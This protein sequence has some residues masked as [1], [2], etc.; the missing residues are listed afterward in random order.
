VQRRYAW[1]DLV[2]WPLAAT[3]ALPM[4]WRA[5]QALAEAIG[6]MPP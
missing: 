5:A 6:A 1:I 2:L 3:V 4:V